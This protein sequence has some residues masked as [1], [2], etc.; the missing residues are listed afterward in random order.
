MSIIPTIFNEKITP[1]TTV[2]GRDFIASNGLSAIVLNRPGFPRRHFFQELEKIGFESVISVESS[3]AYYDIDELSNKYPY[4]R[5]LLPKKEISIGEQINLAVSEIESP[6][7][8]VL[9]S[10]LKVI[11]GG[12]AKKMAE[13]LIIKNDDG[14]AKTENYKR[15]CTIPVI[16]NSH[17][18]PLPTLR[19]PAAR[20]NKIRAAI[21]EPHTEG[22]KSLYPFDGIGIYDR[23]RFIDL[24]G[25]DITLKNTYWQFLDFGFRACLWGEEV[26]L[27]LQLKLL[28][29][30][31]PVVEDFIIDES[32][33][34]FFLKNLAPKFYGDYADLPLHRFL[35]FLMKSREDIFYAWD[36]FNRSRD[37]VKKNKFKWKCD[38][39]GVISRWASDHGEGV[40]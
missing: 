27:S 17:Y 25:F 19:V 20:K 13:R 31:D 40:Q 24:G 32:Y 14:K 9:R 37:W 34:R 7:F 22:Q 6:L 18:Q 12:T 10:D 15:L 30:G 11:A 39:H 38:G 4:V 8:F 16:I 33:W 1:Y 23:R 29:E 35:P 3:S 5:F 36:E 2:G 26:A 21:M 28:S